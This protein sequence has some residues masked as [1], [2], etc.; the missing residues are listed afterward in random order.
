MVIN[1]G[2]K[3]KKYQRDNHTSD[4]DYDEDDGKGYD[5]Q[6]RSRQFTISSLH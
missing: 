4:N 2:R 3:G 1:S 6:F 5:V